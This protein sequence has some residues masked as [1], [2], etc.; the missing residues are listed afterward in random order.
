MYMGLQ[1]G[2]IFAIIGLVLCPSAAAHGSP[3]QPAINWRYGANYIE[4]RISDLPLGEQ[5]S[6]AEAT[7]VIEV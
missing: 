1:I 3:R 5:G 2:S 6:P 4:V 7:S